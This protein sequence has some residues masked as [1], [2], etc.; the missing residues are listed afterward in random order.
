VLAVNPL[1]RSAAAGR[2]TPTGRVGDLPPVPRDVSP[3]GARPVTL[4]GGGVA[5]TRVRV[6]TATVQDADALVGLVGE[7]R[8]LGPVRRTLARR[9]P[10]G[11]REQCLRLLADP[12]RRVVVAVDDADV[13][14][15]AAVL[16]A[17][18]AGGLL[19]PPS[20]YVSHLLVSAEHRKRG[21][22]RALVAAAAGYADELG[23]D[24]V[25]VGVTPTGRDANRFFARLGFAP[26]VIRRIAP[27]AAVRRALASAEP[28][29]DPRAAGRAGIVRSL[30]RPRVRR[31]G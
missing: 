19:D 9:G 22:G 20:V 3:A 24:S 27:V 5:R 18:T 23:V 25:V 21:A 30:P 11:A 16:G 29:A 28:G 1:G 6:R 4:A 10:E 15:G 14:L 2:D 17:D 12:G 13:L 8:D 26:Q 31:T 7:V